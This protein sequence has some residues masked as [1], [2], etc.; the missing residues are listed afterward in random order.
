MKM[1]NYRLSDKPI[2]NDLQS[3]IFD[4]IDAY[5]EDEA[6]NNQKFGVEWME[7]N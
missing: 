7:E 3:T 1:W 2:V 6:N 4:E 5:Q